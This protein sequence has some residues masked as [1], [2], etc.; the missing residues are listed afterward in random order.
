M[1]VCRP[2]WSS[3]I[4]GEGV[5]PKGDADD[6][7]NRVFK[8]AVSL[9]EQRLKIKIYNAVLIIDSDYGDHSFKLK[10]NLPGNVMLLNRTMANE[11]QRLA[12]KGQVSGGIVTCDLCQGTGETLLSGILQTCSK[13]KGGGKMILML[14]K[15]EE[16][17][18]HDK[19]ERTEI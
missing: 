4:S 8:K 17:N 15:T 6:I 19:R 9:L 7:G 1:C 3:T 13:C 2:L 11:L 10:N 18:G 14:N 16:N 12:T 5:M